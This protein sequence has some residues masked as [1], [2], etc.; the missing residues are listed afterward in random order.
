MSTSI[1]CSVPYHIKLISWLIGA[2]FSFIRVLASASGESEM[3][4]TA[5]KAPVAIK[6]RRSIDSSSTR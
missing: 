2:V 4:A 5:A 6:V 1:G 3:N